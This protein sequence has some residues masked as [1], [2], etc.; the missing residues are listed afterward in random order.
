MGKTLNGTKTEVQLLLSRDDRSM[1]HQFSN[2]CT[3]DLYF[4]QSLGTSMMMD[5]DSGSSESGNSCD[6]EMTMGFVLKDTNTLLLRS[7]NGQR[8]I[9]EVLLKRI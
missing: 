2:A 3:Y 8:M 1:L 5:R 9:S 6:G 7:Y 4:G